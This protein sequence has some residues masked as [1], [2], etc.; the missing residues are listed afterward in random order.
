MQSRNIV[1]IAT[2]AVLGL[3]AVYLGNAYFSGYEKQQARIIAAQRQVSIVVATQDVPF[4]AALNSH[5][6]RLASWPA[7]SVPAGAFSSIDQAARGNRVAVLP[8][9]TGEPVLASK[10][11]GSDGRATLSSSLPTGKL[12]YAIPINDVSGVGGFVRP[13]DVV[14]VLLTY[15]IPGDHTGT[16]DK[17]TDVVVEAA[18]VLGI[19]QVFDKSEIKPAVPKTATLEVDTVGAQRLALSVQLGTLSLAL[20][21][22]ADQQRGT[23]QSVTGRSLSAGEI[24]AAAAP[25]PLGASSVHRSVAV[26]RAPHSPAAPRATVAVV[27]GSALSQYEVQRVD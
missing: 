22:V 17:M 14:D 8:I 2:A 21:N 18:P 24:A 4:G 23:H 1:A 6:L 3:F 11:S 10:L 5:N 13:G 15:P 20:R 7:A 25:R 26:R 12:A 9:A 19:D 27:R 16:A